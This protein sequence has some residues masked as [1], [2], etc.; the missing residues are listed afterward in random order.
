MKCLQDSGKRRQALCERRLAIYKPDLP[1]KFKIHGFS[2]AQG[3][4]SGRGE[5]GGGEERKKS[6]GLSFYGSDDDGSRAFYNC[7]IAD[8]TGV[9]GP[10]SIKLETGAKLQP[11]PGH[12]AT[13]GQWQAGPGGKQK[14]LFSLID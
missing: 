4:K 6:E 5:E 2:R 3:L 9:W 10:C 13:S 7:Y 11:I 14:A 12:V 1:L 8:N